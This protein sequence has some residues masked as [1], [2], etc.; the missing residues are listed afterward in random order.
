[1]CCAIPEHKH[2]AEWSVSFHGGLLKLHNC[3]VLVLTLTMTQ[4]RW[5]SSDDAELIQVAIVIQPT[6]ENGVTKFQF[7]YENA[8]FDNLYFDDPDVVNEE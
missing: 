1:L 4:Q 6:I 5:N 8:D 2:S 7:D 3:I